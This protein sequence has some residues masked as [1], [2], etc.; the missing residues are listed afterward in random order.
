MKEKIKILVVDDDHSVQQSVVSM[1]LSR[2]GIRCD[3]AND[4]QEAL[5]RIET[6]Q[7]D[8]VITDT[9][10]PV[11][12]GIELIQEVRKKYPQIR[13]FSLFS[14]LVGSEITKEDVQELGVLM[15]LEKSQINLELLPALEKFVKNKVNI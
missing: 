2:T 7:P 13:I 6:L 14:G 12:N 8:I 5:A 11:K 3:I 4:G 15:V 9:N 10:M 1:I